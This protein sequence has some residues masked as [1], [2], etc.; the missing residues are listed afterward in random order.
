MNKYTRTDQVH[1]KAPRLPTF[2]E[3][4]ELMDYIQIFLPTEKEVNE[5]IRSAYIAVFDHFSGQKADYIGKV[6]CVV[7]DGGLSLYIWQDDKLR[8]I[9]PA[10]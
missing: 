8:S 4:H 7:W 6:M 1:E 5:A 10:W 3:I 2:K 9:S